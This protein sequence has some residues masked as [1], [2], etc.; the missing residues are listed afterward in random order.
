MEIVN[1]G[2]IIPT[3]INY[4]S[5]VLYSNITS[6]KSIYP[7]LQA[8]SI[9]KSVLGKDIPYLKIGNGQ[10]EVFYSAAIHANEWI[11]SPLLMK[12]LANYCLYTR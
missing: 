1:Y 6:L 8:G 5:K 4:G 7:F 2:S 9:G 12:F 3:N 10:N 11:T